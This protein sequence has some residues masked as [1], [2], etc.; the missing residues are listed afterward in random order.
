MQDLYREKN[1]TLLRKMK[2]TKQVWKC[3]MCR[4]TKLNT[5]K[6]EIILKGIYSQWQPFKKTCRLLCRNQFD[7]KKYTEVPRTLKIR[8]IFWKIKQF[9][10]FTHIIKLH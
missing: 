1:K 4:D 3:A 5:I 2:E 9:A 7:S 10:R 6:T 8:Q